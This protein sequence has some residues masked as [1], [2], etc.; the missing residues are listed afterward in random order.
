MED[1]QMGYLSELWN[2][3]HEK[4]AGCYQQKCSN[5]AAIKI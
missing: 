2:Y 5:K 3:G 4:M 1:L